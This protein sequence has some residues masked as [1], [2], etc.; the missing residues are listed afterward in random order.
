M[1]RAFI[2]GSI[3]SKTLRRLG[4]LSDSVIVVDDTVDML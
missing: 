1:L 4:P 3:M 2:L